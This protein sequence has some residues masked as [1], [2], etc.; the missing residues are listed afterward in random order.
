MARALKVIVSAV[1]GVVIAVATTTSTFASCIASRC[2]PRTIS[3]KEGY[4]IAVEKDHLQ[5]IV[6][7]DY[8]GDFSP[9]PVEKAEPVER[10]SW[11]KVKFT[12]VALISC[13]ILGLRSAER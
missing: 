13:L 7:I 4:F 6:V 5:I 11:A 2:T 9:I 10:N 8:M 3:V 1:V 12:E